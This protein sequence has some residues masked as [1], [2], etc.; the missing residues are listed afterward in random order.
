MRRMFPILAALCA[1]FVLITASSQVIACASEGLRLCGELIVPSLFPFFVLSL[2][3]GK[4]GFPEALGR[5]LSPLTQQLF[6]VSG[7]GATALFIGLTGGYP[8]GAAYLAE[9]LDQRELS[10]REAERLLGFC[11]NSGPAFLVGAVGAGVFDSVKAGLLLYSA[12]IMAALGTGVLLRSDHAPDGEELLP[13]TAAPLPFA[14]ALSEA[15]RGAVPALLNVC[16]FVILFTV[17]TGLLEAN[18]FLSFFSGIL[19][20]F[21]PLEAQQSRALLLGFWELGSGVGALR[22][23]ALSP[24]SLALSAGI[25]GWGGVSVLFQSLA[26]LADLPVKPGKMLLGRMISAV[27]GAAFAWL[28]GAL[29][30]GQ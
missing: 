13:P 17:F 24:V 1:L 12:H 4:L 23:L 2:L 14:Q 3:L 22:G 27:L 18:G 7:K 9:L 21:L 29:F 5:R 20:R 11:N 19:T 26:V 16:G 8:M 10:P 30:L 28:L 6:H 15:V 25:V